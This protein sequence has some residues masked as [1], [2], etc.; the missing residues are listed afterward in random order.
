MKLSIGIVGLPNVGKSTL[1]K[2]LTKKQVS[3]ENYPFCTIDPNV[4]VVQVPDERLEKLARFSFSKK[5]VPAVVEFV[6]IAGLVKGA[7]KGEGLGNQ[8]LARIREVD[9]IAEVVRVFENEKIIHV[10]KEINPQSDIGIIE[11]E[12][13]LADLETVNKRLI[14]LEKEKKAGYDKK[15]EK[16]SAVVEKLRQ[17]LEKGIMTRNCELTDEEREI[18]KELCLLTFKP[19]LY[20]FNSSAKNIDIPEELKK[21]NYVILDFKAEEDLAEMSDNEKKE[22]EPSRLNNLIIEAYKL[23]GLINFLTTGDDETRSWTIKKGANAPEAGS[24]IHTDFQEKFIKADVIDWQILLNVG[25]YA[26]ARENGL[27]RT[28]GKNYIVKDGDVII[29]KIAP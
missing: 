19:V 26:N 25:S 8:F 23:L 22:L 7:S 1:F 27:V 12:L 2:L 4:G 17:N 14:K 10:H 28:E 11:T 18:V 29:F 6:D 24:A 21:K 3:I 20:V 15:M 5:I 13:I 9:V 16:Q